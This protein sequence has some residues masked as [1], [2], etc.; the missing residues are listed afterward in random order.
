MTQLIVVGVLL[1]SMVAFINCSPVIQRPG[2]EVHRPEPRSRVKRV[3]DVMLVSEDGQTAYQY[4]GFDS[5]ESDEDDF[6][7]TG[8]VGRPSRYG[9]S[10]YRSDT[11]SLDTHGSFR[12]I[13]D[14]TSEE[15]DPDSK[16]VASK[17]SLEESAEESEESSEESEESSEES[18]EY[19]AR[20]HRGR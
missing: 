15:F 19:G 11:D 17:E 5:D 16:S 12:S 13:E 20:K 7:D 10:P 1:L 3:M 14:D 6:D 2:E 8:F 18:D 9:G 4:G